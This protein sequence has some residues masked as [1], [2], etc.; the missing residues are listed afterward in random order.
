MLS[1]SFEKMIVAIHLLGSTRFDRCCSRCV[2]LPEGLSLQK[3]SPHRFN[4]FYKINFTA[5]PAIK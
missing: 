1:G 5:K 2:I 3:I 4:V